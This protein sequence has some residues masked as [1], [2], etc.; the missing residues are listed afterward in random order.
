[1]SENQQNT[2]DKLDIKLND[3]DVELFMSY[4]L[5]NR[6]AKIGGSAEDLSAIFVQPDFQEAII[7]ECLKKHGPEDKAKDELDI[8]DF[9][10][11]R[12]DAESIVNWAGGH[13]VDFFLKAFENAT[14]ANR[15]MEPM[16]S[17]LM[18][19]SDGTET[20][21]SKTPSAGPSGQSQAS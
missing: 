16:M 6:L 14:E 10:L 8:E 2:P 20:S 1:M 5:L 17:A 21:T 4:A 12:D 19:S 7:V 13:I 18:S 11:H 15:R 9:N 3:K